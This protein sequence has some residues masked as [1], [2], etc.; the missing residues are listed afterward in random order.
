MS[1]RHNFEILMAII[2]FLLTIVSGIFPF[3]KRVNNPAGDRKSTRLNSS[4][5]SVSRMPSSA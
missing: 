5:S 3:V 1:T 2:I 4:H